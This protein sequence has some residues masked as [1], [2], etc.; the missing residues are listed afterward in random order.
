PGPL[1]EGR[2]VDDIHEQDRNLTALCLHEV[3]LRR[4]WTGADLRSDDRLRRAMFL[5]ALDSV[6]SATRRDPGHD[7]HLT[8]SRSYGNLRQCLG[9]RK[10][11]GPSRIRR[12]RGETDAD[13]RR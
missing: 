1:R 12:T 5:I 10:P 2:E 7:V 11:A 3:A 6:Q 9:S 8:A 4:R 13:L